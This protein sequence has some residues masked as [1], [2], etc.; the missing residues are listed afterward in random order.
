MGDTLEHSFI[1]EIWI[2]C[3]HQKLR[4]MNDDILFGNLDHKSLLILTGN[5]EKLKETVSSN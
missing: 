5:S 2:G 1:F 4:M 3:R